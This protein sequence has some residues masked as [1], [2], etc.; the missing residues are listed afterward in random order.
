MDQPTAPSLAPLVPGRFPPWLLRRAPFLVFVLLY[1]AFSLLTYG[2]WGLTT[3]EPDVYLRGSA[4]GDYFAG[5][6]DLVA[7]RGPFLADGNVSYCHLYS[8][9]LSL[10]NPSLSAA[11][12]QW[13]NLLFAI[14][15]FLAAY[16]ILL[17]LGAAP[18]L[19]LSGPL[20]LFLTPRLLGNLPINPKDAPFAVVYLV[21]LFLLIRA[22]FPSRLP[23]LL[24]W[25][26]L[27]AVAF[28]LRPLGL[29]LP[30]L[31]A[32]EALSR[33]SFKDEKNP[34]TAPRGGWILGESFLITLSGF[35]LTLVFWPYLRSPSHWSWLVDLWTR[36]PHGGAQLFFG[37]SVADHALPWTYFPG[38][39]ALST[40]TVLLSLA[41]GGWAWA[42]ISGR[43][44]RILWGALLVNLAILIIQ[45]PVC[46]DTV[47]HFLYLLPILVTIAAIAFAEAY[48]RFPRRRLLLVSLTALGLLLPAVESIRLH[49]YQYLYLSEWVGGF[50]SSPGRF[51]GD[52]WGQSAQEGLG[53]L[54][55]RLSTDP[56]R[57][58]RVHV[59]GFTAVVATYYLPPNA[60][61][62]YRLEDSDY[63]V[64]TRPLEPAPPGASLLHRVER[65]GVPLLW[66]Y[67][68]R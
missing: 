44:W 47:R 49:P 40:P 59:D 56:Q 58:F 27:S 52:Y 64:G 32:L 68:L 29:T 48:S 20:F 45:R 15:L 23:R 4:L 43:A 30:L 25:S 53:F 65:E 19:S 9:I 66:I 51:P 41:I 34:A 22:P 5:R 33:G 2:Q 62:T 1:L 31:F 63:H 37:A 38:W 11:H 16:E 6:S 21:A 18:L 26:L 61:W 12:A 36:F 35:L 8:W 57:L 28:C 42:G 7:T 13:L 3:D 55:E 67:Q 39:L 14:P 17:S 54:R 24:A 50:R 60:K 46:Y 10:L